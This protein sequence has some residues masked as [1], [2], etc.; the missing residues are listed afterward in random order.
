[1]A[2]R[3]DGHRGAAR[4][5]HQGAQVPAGVGHVPRAGIPAIV[6]ERGDAPAGVGTT[7][8][9]DGGVPVELRGLDDYRRWDMANVVRGRANGTVSAYAYCRLGD[10]TTDQFRGLAQIQRDFDVDI[11][12]TNRQNF[13]L[14]GLTEEQL[15]E[16]HDRLREYDMHEPGVE[17]ARDVVSCPGADTCNIAVR[18]PAASPRTSVARSTRRVSPRS[19]AC[20][21][22]SPGARTRAASTTSPTSA[23]SASS[24]AAHGKSAPGY[25]MLLGGHIGNMEI[26][27]GEKA[28]KL[29]AKAAAEGVVRSSASSPTS[30][31]RARRSPTGSA[32]PAA[33]PASVRC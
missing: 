21:S 4:A 25:Q 22:T 17:L 26:A 7:V 32:G 6:E 16:L 33:R 29:P 24:G 10:I 3:H 1:M 20:A 31:P 14:R 2:R 23:S 12:I 8:S 30:A 11:R 5:D 15:P 9:A 28:S 13:V 19:A 18:S 27:F